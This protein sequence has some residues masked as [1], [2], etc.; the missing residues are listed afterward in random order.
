MSE[1]TVHSIKRAYLKG[2]QKRRAEDEGDITVLPVNK[3]GRPVLLCDELDHKV[4]AY[5]KGVRDVG[6]VV[7]ARIAIA[8][9]KG[10]LL[11]TDKMKLLEYGGHI[12]LNT[13]WVYSLLERMNFVKRKA[14]T[15]KR[16]H[17]VENFA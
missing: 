11:S 1:T 12:Q 2:V 13:T 5:L 10:I 3:R 7:S 4:Q 17:T 16:K 9:A 6:G 14:T 15:A 8:A